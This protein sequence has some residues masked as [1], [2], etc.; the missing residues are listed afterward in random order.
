MA[1]AEAN[2]VDQLV[3]AIGVTALAAV[4]IRAQAEPADAAHALR[5]TLLG[6]GGGGGGVGPAARQHRRALAPLDARR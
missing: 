1:A 2:T 6:G 5:A 3:L 4:S